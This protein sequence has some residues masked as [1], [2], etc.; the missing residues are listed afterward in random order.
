MKQELE[1]V[2]YNMCLIRH[3]EECLIRYRELNPSTIPVY[4]STG[5]E[6]VGACLGTACKGYDKVFAQHRGHAAY[7]SFGGNLVKLKD[8]ILLRESGCCGGRS[9]SSD[10]G[11]EM[12]EPHHG[13][14]AENIPLAAG[15]ALGSGKKTIAIFGDGAIEED[16]ALA[17]LGFI[18]THQ[19]PVLLVC[20]DNNLAVLT[21][22]KERR[23]WSAVRVAKAFEIPAVSIPD[24]P[25]I[26]LSV[27][28]NAR[29]PLFVEVKTHRHRWHVGIGQDAGFDPT[30]R[31]F[32]LK[33]RL[34][35]T[36]KEIDQVA[37][38]VAEDAWKPEL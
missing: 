9:G 28:K 2:L 10:V 24:K 27:L 3:F 16:Y 37:Q 36:G 25:D 6:A 15:Y 23:S 19:L 22:V 11:S 38:A 30:D 4:L 1:E 31:L 13:L 8:E 12:L 7:I 18:G 34:G 29:L 20:E 5:Q 33:E 26:L 32:E 35:A 14:I 17:T 21:T